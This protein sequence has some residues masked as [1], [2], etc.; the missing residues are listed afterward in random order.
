MPWTIR[1][2]MDPRNEIDVRRLLVKAVAEEIWRR[3]GGN[4]VLN[5]MEA[6][7]H[8]EGLLEQAR[9]VGTTPAFA[10]ND[11]VAPRPV[12]EVRHLRRAASPKRPRRR[13]AERV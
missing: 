2:M 5:W 11:E 3:C 12:V 6:E 9:P 8:V 7:W 13:V 4:E 10:A 1:P